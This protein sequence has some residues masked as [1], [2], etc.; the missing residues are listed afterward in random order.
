MLLDGSL[1]SV[2][3]RLE[4]END[5]LC[6]ALDQWEADNPAAAKAAPW[7]DAREQWKAAGRP[8]PQW[9]ELLLLTNDKLPITTSDLDSRI[10]SLS[11]MAWRAKCLAKPETAAKYRQQANA[12]WKRWVKTSEFD[13]WQ[14]N[15]KYRGY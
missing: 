4:A 11:S 15:K 5:R 3:E 2:V 9:Y 10:Y 13:N 8:K 1:L 7:Y 14:F 6:A 12:R